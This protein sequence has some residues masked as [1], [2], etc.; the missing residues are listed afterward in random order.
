[1]AEGIAEAGRRRGGGRYSLLLVL[2]G[3]LMM[4]AGG[5]ASTDSRDELGAVYFELGNAYAELKEWQEARSAYEQALAA[6]PLLRKAAYNLSRVL[7]RL[8]EYSAAEQRLKAL[9]EE[10][11]GNAILLETLAWVYV[12]RD[13]IVRAVETYRA[14]LERQPHAEHALYNLARLEEQLGNL[15]RA[16]DYL[17]V[18]VENG[19][20]DG[21]I[22]FRLGRVSAALENG[23]APGWLARAVEERPESERYRNALAVA[24]ARNGEFVRAAELYA[25]LAEEVQER[26]GRYHY[27]RAYLLITGV[28]DYTR[29]IEALEQALQA[30]YRDS[31]GLAEL[32][33]YP[34]LLDPAAV[35]QVLGEYGVL[36][37]S[38]AALEAQE[39]RGVLPTAGEQYEQWSSRGK[40]E[41]APPPLQE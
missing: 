10:D 41:A 33:G 6:D 22:Y 23:E 3:L 30:G 9:L 14:V 26:R 34:D 13:E 32:L 39:E 18:L 5:C 1:M 15:K 27:R 38:K 25:E 20:A 16:R 36:E 7:V 12:Q 21:E 11:P 29:G 4:L 37:A 17:L 40:G 35:E 2:L 8:G 28:D 31:A 19:T 24:Y